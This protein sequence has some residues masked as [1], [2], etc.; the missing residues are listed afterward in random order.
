MQQKKA[1]GRLDRI[2]TCNKWARSASGGPEKSIFAQQ[3]SLSCLQVLMVKKEEIS[4]RFGE[5]K[6][7]IG[8]NG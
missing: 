8:Q 1:W 2:E 6:L 4:K 3:K 5:Q 7:G